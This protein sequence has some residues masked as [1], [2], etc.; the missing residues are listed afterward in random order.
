M[1]IKINKE[2][3]PK[4]LPFPKLMIHSKGTIILAT[5]PTIGTV[6]SGGAIHDPGYHSCDWLGF[7][8]FDGE[9]TLSN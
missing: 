8:D 1:N 9:I 3:S 4:E 2:K 7:K 6:I 5:A